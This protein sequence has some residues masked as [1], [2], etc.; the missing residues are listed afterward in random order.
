MKLAA[1]V[2]VIAICALTSIAARAD[3]DSDKQNRYVVTPLISDLPNTAPNQDP[4][5]QNAW[6]VAFTPGGSPFWIA[7]NATGCSTLYDGAGVPAGG[8][9]PRKVK[10][11]LPSGQ[12]SATSCMTVPPNANP[13]PTNAA[14]TGMVWNPTSTF[15]V[16]GTQIAA[17]F[18]WATEDGTISAWAPTL[19]DTSQ[20]ILAADNSGSNA[21]YKGLVFGTNPRGVFLYAT[22]F[23]NAKIDVFAP[24]PSG[25]NGLFQAANSTQI[26]GNFADPEIPAGFAPFGIQNI[27][28][29]LFVTYA[30]QNEAKH[31]DVAGKGNGFVDIFDTS[32][33]LIGRFASQGTLNSPWGVSRASFAFGRFSGD[34]LIGNFG[35][36]RITAFGN[37][38]KPHGLL[39]DAMTHKPLVIDGL[40][41]ITLGGGRNSDSDVLYFTAGPNGEADGL[42]GTITPKN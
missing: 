14:P 9:P 29:N 3:N 23:H 24:Q 37:D 2:S 35:D 38:G 16:P 39:R 28:G 41:T 26:P 31:D 30:L 18:I 10:I 5:L 42:F 40:W 4:V 33:N 32:G 11:P 27:N 34:I 36:G 8:P 20:A 21:V 7:D 1:S 15:L 13:P 25:S 19:S 6:G 22:D 17:L 12:P